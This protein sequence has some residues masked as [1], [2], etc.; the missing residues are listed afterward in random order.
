MPNPLPYSSKNKG[1]DIPEEYLAWSKDK[2]PEKMDALLTKMS[3]VIDK[4]LKSYGSGLQE[5]M[6]KAKMMAVDAFHTY[7]SKKGM[8]LSSYLHQQLQSLHREKARRE[9]TVHVP[10]NILLQRNKLY[11]AKKD[12]ED[13]NDREPTLQELSDTTGIPSAAIERTRKYRSTIPSSSGQSEEGDEIFSR[14]RNPDRIWSD[15]VYFDL[16]P[17]DKII[18]EMTTGYGGSSII[19]KH[20]I[21]RKLKI[22]PAAVSQRISKI[23]NRLQEMPSGS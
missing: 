8:A 13:Q 23:I 22:S 1:P 12:F 17:V 5:L 7:D 9:Y 6:P 19:P 18:F 15:Y 2:N 11:Q 14:V 21:A 16:D 4:S 10:E 3:P 20:E